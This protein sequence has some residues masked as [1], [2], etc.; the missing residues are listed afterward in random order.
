MNYKVKDTKNTMLSIFFY[1]GFVR[2]LS[3]STHIILSFLLIKEDFA[4]L[5]ILASIN[6]YICG[7][8]DFGIYQYLITSKNL[9]KDSYLV[10]RVSFLL[11]LVAF[12]IVCFLSILLS[13]VY[14]DWRL[15]YL[16]IGINIL[17]PLN[18][19]ITI[20]KIP[21]YIKKQFNFIGKINFFSNLIAVIFLTM[22]L[23]FGYGI[24]S[25]LIY[26]FAITFISLILI[27]P[28]AKKIKKIKSNFR[29]ILNL[30]KKIRWLIFN[31]FSLNISNQGNLLVLIFLLNPKDLAIL[32]FAIRLY[33][34]IAIYFGNSINHVMI[35]YFINEKKK[36][37]NIS[38]VFIHSSYIVNLCAG[39]FTIIAILI[40]PTIVNIAWSSK[41]NE[42]IILFILMMSTFPIAAVNVGLSVN[43]LNFKRKFKDIFLIKSFE[44]LL[45]II[46]TLIGTYFY[47]L[48]GS[49]MVIVLH[50]TIFTLY[51]FI[52]SMFLVSSSLTDVLSAIIRQN[53]S[54]VII[55]AIVYFNYSQIYNLNISHEKQILNSLFFTLVG[56]MIY[57]SIHFLINRNLLIFVWK[58]TK[59]KI[60]L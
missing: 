37:K 27:I 47:G 58:Y 12:L 2:I 1:E 50:K 20:L 51:A 26:Q 9:D 22:F 31:N 34:V 59:K 45:L 40:L 28:K 35:P 10:L 15:F 16:I 23:I 49:V 4:I 21:F 7:F 46:F 42:S 8:K 39:I 44:G 11:N 5:A 60:K 52:K 55:L 32:Y 53:L 14:S 19:Y 29:I 33:E 30:I 3:Y 25:L 56:L 48:Y 57:V 17:M 36:N 41:W 18:S 38:N 24:F 54:L 6:L 43:F 13:K